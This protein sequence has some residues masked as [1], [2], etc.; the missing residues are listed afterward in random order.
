MRVGFDA[1][2][3]H[4]PFPPGVERAVRGVLTALEARERLEVVRLVPPEGCTSGAWRRRLAREVRRH[5]LDGLHSFTSA[6]PLFGPGLRVQTIHEVP[7]R[8]GVRE[9]ADLAHRWWASIGALR[10]DRVVCPTEHVA[11]D[12]R[13]R[14]LPGRNRV[15]VAPWG[16]GAPF[17]EEAAGG[18]VDAEVIRAL[19][20]EEPY[21]LLLGATREKKRL[22]ATL[23]GVAALRERGDEEVR[24]VVTGPPDAALDRAR[25]L[26]AELGLASRLLHHESIEDDALPSLLRRA[27]VVPVLSRS[28]G[29][30]LPVLEALACG[31]PVLVPPRGAQ[32][33]VAGEA[34][35]V[36][37]PDDAAS[38]AAGIVTARTEREARRE[39]GLARAAQFTWN[40]AARR[41][42]AVWEEL[43]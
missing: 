18:I 21:A 41:I 19:G 31:T 17:G 37:E 30:A 42:E 28:E 26:A 11:R 32:T 39:V 6:F 33:E 36:V 4:R 34:G 24:L 3:L 20:I 29:F 25:N 7:W 22:D 9:N 14:F 38:V 8:H 35:I 23:R 43:A 15:R 12:V 40:A 13:R 2:V 5:G 10:A 16:V 27:A 1:S